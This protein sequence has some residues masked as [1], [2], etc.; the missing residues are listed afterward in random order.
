MIKALIIDDEKDARFLLKASINETF[1]DKIKVLGEANS[2]KT[3][4]KAIEKFQPDLIF[5][6]VKMRDGTGFDLL[7]QLEE[8][9]FEIIFVTAYDKYAIKAFEFSAFG[10]IMKPFKKA[11]LETI[12]SKLDRQIKNTQSNISKRIK[13]LVENYGD[14]K[15]M[16]KLVVSNIDGFKVVNLVDL[17]RLEG[18]GNYTNFI[19]ANSRKIT[20]SKNLREY[21]GL[22]AEYGFY[23]IHQSTIVNLRHVI[24]F[25][26]DEG[27][28]VEMSDGQS[29]KLSRYRKAGFMERFL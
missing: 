10:Y 14:D 9:Q 13:V 1:S 8:I 29:S 12:I 4:I 3:G 21:E 11:D 5:L 15:K 28:K 27:G 6:D 2:V 25:K 19:I 23:R 17:I 26:K 22:L 16:Q 24:G 7:N 18:D 20:S